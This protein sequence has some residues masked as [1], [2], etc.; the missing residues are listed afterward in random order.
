MLR[1]LIYIS[2]AWFRVPML[3]KKSQESATIPSD[4]YLPSMT[5]PFGI[6]HE[7]LLQGL[8]CLKFITPRSD[9]CRI[10]LDEWKTFK[11]TYMLGNLF[12]I[13]RCHLLGG[14]EQY[15]VKMGRDC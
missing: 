12:E 3:L 1:A 14:T 8:V 15:Y 11:E 7:T 4:Q 2:M 10:N 5:E 13:E 6:S 9:K